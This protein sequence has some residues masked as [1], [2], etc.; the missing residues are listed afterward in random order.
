MRRA[1]NLAFFATGNG[2]AMRAISSAIERGKLKSRIKLLIS[3]KDDSGAVIWARDS[4]VAS[5]LITGTADSDH[6]TCLDTLNRYNIDLILLTGYMRKIGRPVLDRYFP[7]IWNIHPALLPHFGGKGMYGSRVHKAVLAS[8]V[9][10][11]GATI[12]IADPDY[13]TGPIVCQAALDVRVNDTSDSL[14][15]RVK[16]LESELL[17]AA[18]DYVECGALEI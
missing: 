3:N 1:L 17:V 18:I 2:T 13:D 7:R 10:R 9:Q 12:H 5:L 11:T 4:Q 6:A 14:A 16:E 15:D 8:G